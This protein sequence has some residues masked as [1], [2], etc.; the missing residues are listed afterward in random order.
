LK[1]PKSTKK[2]ARSAEYTKV[3][4]EASNA[5]E[6][7]PAEAEK[8]TQALGHL[9]EWENGK[10]HE[11]I[12]LQKQLDDVLSIVGE[13]GAA[14]LEGFLSKFPKTKHGDIDFSGIVLGARKRSTI[15]VLL[16]RR[17]I[18]TADIVR[19]SKKNPEQFFFSGALDVLVAEGTAAPRSLWKVLLTSSSRPHGLLSGVDA[20]VRSYAVDTKPDASRWL[21][22][23]LLNADALRTDV[24]SS[25]LRSPLASFRFA[26]HLA[27][28][29]AALGAKRK[30]AQ[31]V[32]DVIVMDWLRVFDSEDPSGTSSHLLVLGLL[33][34]AASA[35]SAG[36][37]V[38]TRDQIR[39]VN[40]RMAEAMSIL[41]LRL[42]EDGNPATEDESPWVVNGATLY[43]SVQRYLRA[44]P[45]L[46]SS[47]VDPERRLQLERY[48]G[49]KEVLVG[50][51]EAMEGSGDDRGIRDSVEVALFNA[52]VRQLG[53]TGD[54]A[55]FDVQLHET[56]ISGVMQGDRVLVET[57]PRVIGSG[58]SRI[59]IKKGV[60]TP[61]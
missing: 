8:L 35:G 4:T 25:V 52:G 2:I 45:V 53:N 3:V 47:D 11:L 13:Y 48:L 57:V 39:V 20:L 18:R 61:R 7:S 54:E 60:V 22:Q 16:N 17:L 28:D 33:E 12:D 42:R 49:R 21:A 14:V 56:T 24:L 36:L 43:A 29:H 40:Q 44:L 19:I 1:Q 50:L 30:K 38:A 46:G 59:V 58:E 23:F 9:V 31:A 10:P 51:L 6:L 55:A 5:G 34:L 32:T 15:N 41:S 26:H 37:G 27:L